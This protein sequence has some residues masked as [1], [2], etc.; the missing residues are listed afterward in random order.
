[1]Q[2]GELRFPCALLKLDKS[3]V[4]HE[5]EAGASEKEVSQKS[6]SLTQT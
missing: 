4:Q 5:R 6:R 1:M 3:N 2:S